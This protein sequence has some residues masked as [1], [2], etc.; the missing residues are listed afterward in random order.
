MSNLKYFNQVIINNTELSVLFEMFKSGEYDVENIVLYEGKQNFI[1]ILIDWCACIT[2]DLQNATFGDLKTIIM[3]NSMVDKYS[4][5]INYLIENNYQPKNINNV[6]NERGFTLLH[7]AVLH[8]HK[9]IIPLLEL[10]ADCNLKKNSW[11]YSAKS[12]ILKMIKLKQ[13]F[14]TTMFVFYTPE[15]ILELFNKYNYN[16]QP[17]IKTVQ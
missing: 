8:Y 10:G 7:Y 14:D 17:F 2:N 9:L 3:Y 4:K 6:F 15:Q 16:D 5:I 13:N 1:F 12:R 11:N